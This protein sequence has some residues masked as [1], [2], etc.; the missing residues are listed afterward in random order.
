MKMKR[1]FRLI[2]LVGFPD[3]GK[4]T[5]LQNLYQH[6]SGSRSP[7]LKR[8]EMVTT[9]LPWNASARI[10]I[11]FDGDDYDSVAENFEEIKNKKPDCAV[12][13]L[14]RAPYVAGSTR[15]VWQKWI[16]GWISRN[17]VPTPF[18]NYERF[19][20]HSLLP[21]IH[22]LSTPDGVAVMK[23]YLGYPHIAM[24]ENMAEKQILDILAL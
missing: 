12:I 19:Y 3:S 21:T 22:T 9:G 18:D 13:A 10:L 11:G 14:S 4:T 5:V 20:I 23:A 7:S 1:Q 16:D 8:S 24:C 2:V 17:R 15:Y 6:L